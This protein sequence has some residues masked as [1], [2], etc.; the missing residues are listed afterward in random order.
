[1]VCSGCGNSI[2]KLERQTIEIATEIDFS[3]K[4]RETVTAYAD[5][6][7]Y[8]VDQSDDDFIRRERGVDSY[9]LNWRLLMATQLMGESQVGG[10]L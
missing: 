3:C 2:S 8:M 6:R 10:G 9:N 1:M 7:N 5:K 4:C